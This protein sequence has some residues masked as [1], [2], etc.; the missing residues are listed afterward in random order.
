MR[1]YLL[2][3]FAIVYCTVT[4]SAQ[5]SG[6]VI[7]NY[8]YHED[9]EA[10]PGNW[11]SGGTGNDWALG[12]PNKFVINSA[13]SGTKCWVTGGLSGSSYTSGQRSYVQSPC[14]NF[15]ALA[16]PYIRFKIWWE[17]ESKFDGTN[18]QYSLDGG[19]TWTNVGSVNDP[20]NCL[21]ENWYNY[22]TIT[23]LNGLATVRNGWSGNVQQSNGICVGGG[24]S[25]G[26]V[27]A[28][29]CMNELGGQPSVRFRFTFGAGTTC[30]D[31]DGVAF[32]DIYV[33][34][35]PP[36]VASFVPSCSGDNTYTF[37]D[38]STICPDSW[39][40]DF[41]DP[42]SGAANSSVAQNP[43]HTYPGP[44]VYTVTLTA[45]NLCSGTT[46]AV[47]TVKIYELNPVITPIDCA[48]DNNGSATIQLVPSGGNPTFQWS[49]VPVQTG[50][51]ATNL[52]AGTYTVSLIETG[53]CPA[54]ATVTI[55]EPAILQHTTTLTNASCGFANGSATI[56]ASGGTAPYTYSWLPAVSTSG[57]AFNLAA[58]NYGVTITDVRGCTDVASF[59][60][61]GSPGVQAA[62][63]S[64]VPATCFG[65][66]TG[67]AT[68]TASGGSSPFSYIW[69]AGG[70]TG[71]TAGG[72]SAG[73]YTVTVTDANM[74]TATATTVITQPA[75][76]QHTATVQAATCGLS[77]GS[78]SIIATG[79]TA[80]Y[81]YLWSPSGGT[82]NS[83]S[84]LATGAYLLSIT[85]QQGCTDTVQVNISN[86]PPVQAAISNVLNVDCFGAAT[87][88]AT[89]SV[90]GGTAP[91]SYSWSP[92]GGTGTTA[93]NL[94]AGSYQVTITDA[95]MC[96]ATASTIISQPPALTHTSSTVE[97][98]C[99]SANGSAMVM[100]SGGTL[101][102]TYVWSPNG[103]TGAAA[104][105]LFAG[106]YIVTI[107]DSQSCTDTVQI[108]VGNIGGVQAVISANS[109]VT[110]FG[111]QDGSATVSGTGGLLPYTYSWSP[112]G[113]NG[114]T[115]GGLAA[116]NYFVTVTDA[117]LC[118]AAVA[119]SI[120]QPPAFQHLVSTQS[121]ICGGANGQAAVVVS[122]GTPPYT[123]SWSPTGGS[124]ST[125]QNLPAGDYV[126]LITDAQSCTDTA[127]VTVGTLPSVQ[128]GISATVDVVCF[129]GATGSATVSASSGQ[130]PYTYAWS[131]NNGGSATAQNLTAGTYTVT[132]TDA[133][134]CST[135]ATA[136]ITQPTP[137]QHT[138]ETKPA[139]CGN[140]N[141]SATIMETGGT[142]PYTYAWSPS[143]GTN[144]TALNLSAGNYLVTITDQQGCEDLAQVNIVGIP[145]VQAF[146]SGTVDA[147]CFGSST[148]NATVDAIIGVLPYTYAWSPS[149]GSGATATDLVAGT[150]S[151]TVTDANLCTASATTTVMQPPAMQHSTTVLPVNCGGINGS[152]TILETGGT[153]PYTYIWSPTGGNAATASGLAAGPYVV[154]V[155][156]SQGCL[157]TVQILIGMA[158]PLQ[159]S[160]VVGSPVSCFGLQDGSLN[161]VATGGVLPYTYVWSP[162]NGTSAGIAALASG[163]YSVTVSDVTGCSTVVSV[164][165]SEPSAVLSNWYTSPVRCPG[166]ANGSLTVDTTTGGTGPY[167][168][169]LNQ[170][171]FSDQVVFTPL[172]AG[173]YVLQTQDANGCVALDSFNITSPLPNLVQLG[174]DTTINIGDS[175]LLAGIV[176]DPSAVATY[177]W[178]PPATITCATCPSTFAQ[179]FTTT[180][181]ILQITD[182]AGCLSS[183][184]RVVKVNGPSIYIPNVF[185]PASTAPNDY[186]TVYA[187]FGVQEVELLEVYDRWGE[188]VFADQN[189]A[190]G[191]FGSGW[192]GKVGGKPAASGVY[193]YVCRIRLL[194][195][196]AVDLKGDVTVVR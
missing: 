136:V 86:S 156:D 118:I 61:S 182:R 144:P 72:L 28:K 55:T 126:V 165:L 104:T 177:S 97:A 85:D 155:T 196:S 91:F 77:N 105:G 40:W 29:H 12:T 31:Y 71:P 14:F 87:G 4:A 23:Y 157:D 143:G 44:G 138:I 78:A 59:A 169:A 80:P 37:N 186:F 109:P 140:A 193:V 88:S 89:A 49:T 26:W 24:G 191:G 25:G 34:N 107:T 63:F 127:Q 99:N 43:T 146:I 13:G 9:F 41:G 175:L 19:L 137:F 32:D 20:V 52:A 116:G 8:P 103:G 79:G 83:A 151:V 184:S 188:L 48:G 68:V 190:P 81:T 150:Y 94:P 192:D 121:S 74:C 66:S 147:T 139:T 163:T 111:G 112:A 64:T 152:A 92:S 56:N 51:T 183:D 189:F 27:E 75:Q 174:A 110:C 98:A 145:G 54:T 73:T 154:S 132:V 1:H 129:G 113:G 142:G 115:A 47:R 6:P 149:G 70:N 101:P 62:I 178:T 195:G 160:I 42:V 36:I 176:T 114:P 45:D 135:T 170:S 153:A 172:A 33:Q 100:I 58:G 17:S 11:T 106:N 50:P 185:A 167:L 108:I 30:N 16:N 181:Y 148:G 187:G 194:D 179:P 57:S 39:L 15:T 60:L 131:G 159:A 141:G 168:Y 84:N 82:G 65:A 93:V 117:N 53:V 96:T 134:V 21:N 124:G 173:S 133:N 164:L 22:P 120:A 67:S 38:I 2:L 5:C 122:G 125:A 180:T 130:M 158:P 128:A 171:G 166:E 161:A 90:T 35:A 69:S 95:K 102:Y 76:L 10:G 3:L 119:T 46:T 123:Y 18:L 7:I 162:V